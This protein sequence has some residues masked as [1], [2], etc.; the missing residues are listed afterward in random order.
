MIVLRRLRDS[1]STLIREPLVQFLSL[2][3]AIYGLHGLI[4]P[5]IEEDSQRFEPVGVRPTND[6]EQHGCVAE[7][8][9]P[10]WM[11]I[12]GDTDVRVIRE[13]QVSVFGPAEEEVDT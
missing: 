5:S 4:A 10:G 13:A 8:K 9:Y 12:R 3:A 11:L 6:P 7:V 2:G 1:V